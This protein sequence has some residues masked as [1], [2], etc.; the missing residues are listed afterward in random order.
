[1]IPNWIRN[2]C[3]SCQSQESLLTK[4]GPGGGYYHH[5]QSCEYKTPEGVSLHATHDLVLEFKQDT[6]VSVEELIETI[7]NFKFEYAPNRYAQIFMYFENHPPI[8]LDLAS[9]L[10]FCWGLM[11]HNRFRGGI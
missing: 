7:R 2:Q 10:P 11:A 1:M 6:Q 3:L 8:Q 9:Y 5:C 4:K